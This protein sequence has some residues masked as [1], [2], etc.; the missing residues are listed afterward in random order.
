MT[1]AIEPAIPI[2]HA[3]VIF[4]VISIP[5]FESKPVMALVAISPTNLVPIWFIKPKAA[6]STPIFP[7]VI[8]ASFRESGEIPFCAIVIINPTHG[9]ANNN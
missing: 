6:P 4:S 9:I 1:I 8:A 5:K 2:L 3:F 7:P